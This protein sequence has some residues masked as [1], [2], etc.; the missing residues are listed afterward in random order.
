MKKRKSK[1]NAFQKGSEQGKANAL[2]FEKYT[3]IPKMN[4]KLGIRLIFDSNYLR[5]YSKGY[6]DAFFGIVQARKMKKAMDV[7]KDRAQNNRQQKQKE[8]E[9]KRALFN[10]LL[11]ENRNK[12][13][14]D[15]D[16]VI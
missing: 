11:K 7:I 8:D 1:N 10:D 6:K 9:T 16:R 15:L 5:E 2:N 13:D 4:L 14:N 3:P 12:K